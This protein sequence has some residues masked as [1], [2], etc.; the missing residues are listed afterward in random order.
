M[1]YTLKICE[2]LCLGTLLLLGSAPLSAQSTQCEETSASRTQKLESNA[3]FEVLSAN[4]VQFRDGVDFELVQNADGVST[5]R[6]GFDLD[7]ETSRFVAAAIECRCS[8]PMTCPENNCQETI[9]G[10]NAKCRGGCYKED[11]T[12]CV[13]CQWLVALPAPP[14]EQVPD[15]R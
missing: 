3:Y 12:A 7:D 2:M 14:H 8:S 13:S 4:E 15:D 6:Y 10:G 1:K 11:G 9:V 5:L